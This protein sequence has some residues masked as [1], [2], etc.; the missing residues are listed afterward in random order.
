MLI[1]PGARAEIGRLFACLQYGEELAHDC[2][3]SQEHLAPERWRSSI[4]RQSRQEL[5]HAR[6]FSRATSVIAPLR[7]PPV[8]RP[9]KIFR[10]RLEGA[11]ARGD[12][13]ETLVGQ[14]IVLES[15]GELVLSRMD[16]KFDQYG[17]GFKRVRKV[18]LHQEQGHLAFGG[19]AV[20]DLVQTGTTTVSQV[21]ALSIPYLSLVDGILDE[22]QPVFDVVHA[23]SAEFKSAMRLRLPEWT[24]RA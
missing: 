1:R 8:P 20:R 10:T 9:L 2:A 5:Q 21:R 4:A 23:D 18:L 17:L 7:P 11:C 24:D 3:S 14:Q 19:R 6:I 13:L 16:R 15:F 22:L 12:L